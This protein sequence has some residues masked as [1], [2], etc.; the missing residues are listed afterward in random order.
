[1]S[2]TS[3]TKLELTKIEAKKDC[4]CLAECYGLWLFSHC[5]SLKNSAYTTENAGVA[6]K[7]AELAAACTGAQTEIQYA[8]SRRKKS[9]YRIRLIDDIARRNLLGAFGAT[10]LETNRRI[11]RAALME[12]CC[13]EAF[14]RGTFL[15]CGTVT[16]PGKEYHLEFSVPYQKLS[17]DLI[18]LMEEV[19]GLNLTPALSLRKGSYVV[20]LKDSGQIEDFLTYLGATAASMNLMQVKMYKEMKNNINRKANFETANMDKTYSASAKQIAAIAKISDCHGLDSLPPALQQLAA[21]RLEN[22]EMSLRELSEKLGVTRSAVNHRM[23]K[24]LEAAE[25]FGDPSDL[26]IV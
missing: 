18:T 6:T 10:G 12:P 21:L 2:F 8:V 7:M 4:C 23:K 5:F 20:Y 15:C 13:W 11:N 26:K 3:D 16:D 19:E 1:M 25:K 14:L 9:A 24:L 22:P 17:L